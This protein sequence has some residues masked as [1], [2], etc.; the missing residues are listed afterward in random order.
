MYVKKIKYKNFNGEKREKIAYFL[1]GGVEMSEIEATYPDGLV[2]T[3]EAMVDNNDKKGLLDFYKLVVASSYGVK[4]EDGE[5]FD[6]DPKHLVEFKKS[7]AYEELFL[8][9]MLKQEEADAFFK[10]VVSDAARRR[11][12]EIKAAEEKA[13]LL[14]TRNN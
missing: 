13:E 11:I 9:L 6:R 7:P 10:G 14:R 3:V 4:S 8:D 2:E 1:L 5:S 12:A